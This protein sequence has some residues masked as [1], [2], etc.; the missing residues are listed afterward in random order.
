MNPNELHAPFF[1]VLASGRD[2]AGRWLVT[3]RL[4]T[5]HPVYMGH[6]PGHPV[7]PGVCLL[8]MI[9]DAAFAE[10]EAD[11]KLVALDACKFLLPVLPEGEAIFQISY[12]R[13]E[14]EAGIRIKA[15]LLAGDKVYLKFNGVFSDRLP[16]C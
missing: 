3:V 1:S 10:S 12:T 16:S 7:A 13:M 6:F 5:A 2:A 8:Q 9:R 14:E 4:N 15:E 11:L